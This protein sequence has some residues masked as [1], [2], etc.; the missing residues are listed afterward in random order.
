MT[1]DDEEI[2]PNSSISSDLMGM[3]ES[4]DNQLENLTSNI[5]T[6]A[7]TTNFT[8]SSHDYY[9]SDDDDDDD[10]DDYDDAGDN[11]ANHLQN[12]QM[13]LQQMNSDSLL[14]L[15]P[16]PPATAATTTT[17]N[18]TGVVGVS[19]S[20][21]SLMVRHRSNS[22]SRDGGTTKIINVPP[23][24]AFRRF[25]TT[26]NTTAT[27]TTTATRNVPVVLEKD[28]DDDSEFSNSSSSS[29][30]SSDG[31]G[32]GNVNG[33]YQDVEQGDGDFMFDAYEDDSNLYSDEQ[34]DTA[35]HHHHHHPTTLPDPDGNYYNGLEID[36]DMF[37][38]GSQLPHVDEVKT[39]LGL[40]GGRR[41]TF[42]TF[43]DF[44]RLRLLF[45]N[46]HDENNKK[47][48]GDDDDD[49]HYYNNNN[50][51]KRNR[52]YF[53]IPLLILISI[54]IAIITATTA[55]RRR[56][57]RRLQE[58]I[59]YISEQ[60]ISTRQDLTTAGTPQNLAAIWIATIDERYYVPVQQGKGE[61][62]EGFAHRT[63]VDRYVLTVLYYS[64]GGG[65]HIW[66]DDFG[67]LSK[68]HI[69]DWGKTFT[70]SNGKQL[71]YGV[72]KC[73]LVRDDD[74]EVEVEE[75]LSELVPI[76]LSLGKFYE[77]FSLF[78]PLLP[79][80]LVFDGGGI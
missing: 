32:D 11:K 63:F 62:G 37:G 69:C 55:E 74:D 61:E 40:R 4:L 52:R 18:D 10:D 34:Y 9:D 35:D 48:D 25:G 68:Y 31:D 79:T 64:L 72:T 33:V 36:D 38:P 65:G 53:L 30:F 51:S 1:E 13:E 43:M 60:N 8:S 67:F 59:S 6:T 47:N 46:L 49:D 2:L 5:T 77:G 16:P 20:S 80:F 66:K 12:L 39:F 50:N 22:S 71:T 23:S 78:L 7:T 54:V 3:F 73:G 28:G 75:G 44:R 26:E 58:V 27:T 21:S 19:S 57:G 14:P 24:T 29:D 15:P 56:K 70:T 17:T 41:T 42:F 76:E 45:Q